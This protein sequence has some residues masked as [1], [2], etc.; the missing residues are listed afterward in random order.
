MGFYR[1]KPVT[2]EA[3]Q[4]DGS[5]QSF[6]DIKN[7]VKD[8]CV[9]TK[10]PPLLIIHTLEGDMVASPGDYIVKGVDN[11]FY[12]CKPKIFEQTYEQVG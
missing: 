8:D 12:P 7:F 2:I 6:S 4:F 3:I 5:I 1:K 10:K 9:I 11:E